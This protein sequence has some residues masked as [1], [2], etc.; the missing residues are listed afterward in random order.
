MIE[1]GRLVGFQTIGGRSRKVLVWT[2][3]TLPSHFVADWLSH[4]IVDCI[5]DGC[6]PQV[7]V[8]VLKSCVEF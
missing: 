7:N 3:R 5:L 2:K 4:F 1:M 8:I 6:L